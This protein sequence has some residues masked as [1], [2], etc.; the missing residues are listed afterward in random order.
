MIDVL[1]GA[2]IYKLKAGENRKASGEFTA[3]DIKEAV[4]EEK[5]LVITVLITLKDGAVRLAHPH[6]LN[7]RELEALTTW[8]ENLKNNPR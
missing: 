4:Y 2:W 8:A 1:K 7:M 6:D 3:A 5:G